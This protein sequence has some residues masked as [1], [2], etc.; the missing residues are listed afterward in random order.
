MEEFDDPAGALISLRE[1]GKKTPVKNVFDLNAVREVA[2]ALDE[3]EL[4]DDEDELLSPS[5]QSLLPKKA[6]GSPSKG[7]IWGSIFTFSEK[8]TMKALSCNLNNLLKQSKARSWVCYE[9]FYSEIDRA[10]FLGDNDFS[11]C[12]KDYFPKLKTRKLIRVQW[13]MIRRMM[14]KPRRCSP[15]FFLEERQALAAKR[16]KIRYLMHRKS[17]DASDFNTFKDLPDE[18]AL[19]IVI[20]TRVTARI[21]QPQDGLFSG[22][23]DAVN[24]QDNTYRITFVRQGLGTLTVPDIDVARNEDHETIPISSLMT[25]DRPRLQ[26]AILSPSKQAASSPDHYRV[27]LTMKYRG[28]HPTMSTSPAGTRLE[29]ALKNVETGN[30]GGFPIKFLVLATRLSKILAV[31]KK[32]IS[33]LK[34]MNEKA[35]RMESYGEVFS[36]DFQRRYAGTV[37]ELERINKDLNVCLQGIQQ[38][39]HE[40]SN[41]GWAA[42]LDQ[43]ASMQETCNAEAQM[44]VE[45]SERNVK[46]NHIKDLV[47]SLTSILLQIK[48]FSDNNL[49]P[50]ELASINQATDKIKTRLDHRNMRAF[51]DKVEVHLAHIQNGLAQGGSVISCSN[52]VNNK[53]GTL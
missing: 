11:Q 21:R 14:G 20:G 9:W 41:G 33:N 17:A 16:R 51:A 8:R 52:N 39:C 32:C 25:K 31:K 24:T 5:P 46:S 12:L 19:P 2:E 3:S 13:S 6:K 7:Y 34:E 38:Y 45:T 35:E 44:M 49:K 42:A 27:R 1:S 30:Y 40:S 18:I 22:Q 47:S 37:L 29:D 10:L 4:Y 15:A 26:M 53:I 28:D 43:T 48:F 23:V 50:F 36:R